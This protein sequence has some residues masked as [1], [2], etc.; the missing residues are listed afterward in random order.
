[1]KADSKK[2]KLC[3]FI[4]LCISVNLITGCGD[5]NVGYIADNLGKQAYTSKL[6]DG[7]FFE[8]DD[9]LCIISGTEVSEGSNAQI[10]VY[11]VDSCEM[12][13]TQEICGAACVCAFCETNEYIFIGTI[14]RAA[15]YGSDL[16][17]LNKKTN[18]LSRRMHFQESAIY[19][20][21]YD[22]MD[23][24]FVATSKAAALY[25]YSLSLNSSKCLL[26]DFT[27][28]E[29]VRSIAYN[30]G[31]CYLGIGS[32]ADFVSVDVASSVYESTEQKKI[33]EDSFVYA[34]SVCGK[35]IYF[36]LSDSGS[37]MVLDTETNEV[38][39]TGCVYR[40]GSTEI[41]VEF[42]EC[43][44]ILGDLLFVREGVIVAQY[45][46]G[47]QCSCFN[48]RSNCVISLNSST[49]L[50]GWQHNKLMFQKDL[51]KELGKSYI[52]PIEFLVYD[53]VIYIPSRRFHIRNLNNDFSK[54]FLVTDEPQASC[55][56]ENGIYTANYTS[57]DVY[58]YPFSE[59]EK[60]PSEI[61]MNDDSVYM[62]TEIENQ[63]RPSQ[64]EV[65][66]DGQYLVLGSGPLYGKFGGAVSVYD[67]TN[68]SLVYT[69]INVVDNHTIQ[70]IKCSDIRS[71]NVWLGTSPYGENTSPA[72]LE[73]PSH[74]ILWDIEREEILL[75]IIP[76]NGMKKIPSIAEQDGLVYCVT[77]AAHIF[78]FD[79]NT[80]EK[81]AEN[82]RDDIC[83][84]LSLKDDKL[85]GISKTSV[86]ILDPLT[87]KAE[88]VLD[89]YSQLTHLTQD[90]IS[91]EI[92]V[93]DGTDLLHIYQP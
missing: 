40:E 75:D 1:M 7:M 80:G 15:S 35:D 64:M 50:Q 56:T 84:I 47:A 37:V 39:D 13:Y 51:S 31:I 17:A 54:E 91:G 60:E 19:G 67:I 48:E 69:H 65:T 44:N 25:A 81:V 90:Q 14:S 63:C 59:L 4:V 71:G 22:G 62:I 77:Q 61:Q 79:V 93:F 42:D 70:S 20:M 16:Y 74:L 41:P 23:T 57:C 9:E 86:Y 29:Y 12:E 28:E 27:Q 58:F 53:D 46:S 5:L 85:M 89:G 36:L 33:K 18:V 34:Q 68:E 45:S 78:S 92:Y 52:I 43:I 87:L 32:K 8:K 83:E 72:Y 73:E 76:E 6:L 2:R 30:E 24:V 55:V 3:F 88:M 66:T 82:K 49:F 10:F 26:A 21:A 11:N 38:K